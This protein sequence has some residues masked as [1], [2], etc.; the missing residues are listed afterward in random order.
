MLTQ[1]QKDI[2]HTAKRST[3]VLKI[4]WY[5]YLRGNI[6]IKE[7]LKLVEECVL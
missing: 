5:K 1:K 3:L 4:N 2:N 7:N 6:C